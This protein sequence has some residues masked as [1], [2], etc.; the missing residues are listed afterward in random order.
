MNGTPVLEADRLTV[1]WGAVA[2]VDQVCLKIAAGS[3]YALLGRNGAG[4]SS[5]VRS[6][7][8]QVPAAAGTIRVLGR[9]C[10]RERARIMARVGLVPER[11]DLPPAASAEALAAYLAALDTAWDRRDFSARL[12]AFAVDPRRPFGQLSKGQQRW[13]ALAAALAGRPEL[14]ILDDPTLGLD[15]VAREALYGAIIDELA[16]RGATVL[17]TTHDLAGVEGIASHVGVLA[18]GHLVVSETVDDLKD[19]V[20]RVRLTL[21]AD[22]DL[23]AVEGRAAAL[24]AHDLRR[25]GLLLDGVIRSWDRPALDQL[26][27]T[28]G[29]VTLAQETLSLEEIFLHLGR[30][31]KGARS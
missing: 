9:D 30:S 13:V 2:A 18:G 3:V 7:V 8:G 26:A 14:V 20:R 11:L 6:A 19:G 12:A 28:P 29:V 1:R 17:V 31:E 27:A 22:A 23:A 10:W 16:E 21:A 24:G 5:L 4:K 25:T 15:V